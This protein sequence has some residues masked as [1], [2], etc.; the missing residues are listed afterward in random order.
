MS[1]P[2]SR[3]MCTGFT[4]ML[5]SVSAGII[6][7]SGAGGFGLLL[8]CFTGVLVAVGVSM[9]DVPAAFGGAHAL[10]ANTAAAV[11]LVM[12]SCAVTVVS[13]ETEPVLCIAMFTLLLLGVSLIN[14]GARA[15]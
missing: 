11:G 1:N 13:G 4:V 15:E 3:A 7:H 8:L 2:G 9:T 12:A 10:G 6:I 14:V 5:L